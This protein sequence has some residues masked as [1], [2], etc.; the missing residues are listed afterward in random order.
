MS[1]AE[2]QGRI[3]FHEEGEA[4]HYAMLTED[5]RWWLA[6][7]ANGEMTSE[8][9][10]ANFRRLAAC[11]NACL[12]VDTVTLEQN[13]APFT[14]LREERDNMHQLLR[15]VTHDSEWSCMAPTLQD[16][17]AKALGMENTPA[18]P[19][20]APPPPPPICVGGCDYQPDKKS[21]YA[22]TKCGDWLPF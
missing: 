2:T 21:G 6:L 17:I 11:W 14:A 10:R 9:Q 18:L 12:D 8:R 16:D 15:R 3:N 20:P 1:E 4:N 5:G 22:C 19:V 13:P 7:V